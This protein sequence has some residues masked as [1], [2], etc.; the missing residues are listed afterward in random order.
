L[1]I[2]LDGNCVDCGE[3]DGHV[4]GGRFGVESIKR[5]MGKASRD[6]AVRGP[7]FRITMCGRRGVED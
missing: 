7:L 3:F 6:A 2:R 1:G 4:E 5:T